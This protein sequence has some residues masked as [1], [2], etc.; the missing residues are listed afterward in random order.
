[1]M[2]KN[3]SGQQ[4]SNGLR[5]GIS[6]NAGSDEMRLSKCV[7][8]TRLAVGMRAMSPVLATSIH[9]PVIST[10]PTLQPIII[11]LPTLVTL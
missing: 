7:G 2:S 4:R 5:V 11:R 10:M 1:M 8:L 6:A 9:D 3:P